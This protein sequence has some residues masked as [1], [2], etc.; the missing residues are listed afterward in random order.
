MNKL[1]K[2]VSLWVLPA[3]LLVAVGTTTSCKM[4]RSSDESNP[5]A[6]ANGRFQLVTAQVE[7]RVMVF[8]LDTRDGA[9]WYFQPP[10]GALINGFWSNIPTLKLEDQYWEQVM[11]QM[12]TPKV[13]TGAAGATSLS[14]TQRMSSV[15]TR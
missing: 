14:S 10:Q 13:D 9:T 8:M 11:R 7:G 4:R 1:M 2:T 6:S 3:C 12:L 15:P 5:P